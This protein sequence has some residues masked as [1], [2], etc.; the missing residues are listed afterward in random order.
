MISRECDEE[1]CFHGIEAYQ[2]IVEL[3]E[4]YQHYGVVDF[5]DVNDDMVAVASAGPYA[6]HLDFA[7]HS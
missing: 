3:T 4:L 7:Q 2:L 5:N 6:D 1:N